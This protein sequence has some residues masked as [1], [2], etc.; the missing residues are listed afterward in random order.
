M[1]GN[2]F[3]WGHPVIISLFAAAGV[4]GL[5]T[6]FVELRVAKEPIFP[7]RLLV[8]RDVVLPYSILLLQNIAQTFVSA[9]RIPAV[10]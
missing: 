8:Q 3:A 5:S 2:Q 9:V 6:A 10:R 4:L 1:G 7:L